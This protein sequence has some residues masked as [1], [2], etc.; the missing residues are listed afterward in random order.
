MKQNVQNK[1]FS[2]SNFMYIL[3]FKDVLA[4]IKR[5]KIKNHLTMSDPPFIGRR[6]GPLSKLQHNDW[7]VIALTQIRQKKNY[8]MTSVAF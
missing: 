6:G 2:I 1:N 7:D 4:L 3:Q 8:K 5:N